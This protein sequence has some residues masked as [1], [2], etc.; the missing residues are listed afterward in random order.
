MRKRGLFA[1][2]SREEKNMLIKINQSP[3]KTVHVSKFNKVA[4]ELRRKGWV[5][6]NQITAYTIEVRR[7][8]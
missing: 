3:T 7:I 2:L 1:D 8:P 6:T 5:H 4:P